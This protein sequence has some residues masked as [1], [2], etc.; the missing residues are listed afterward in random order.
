MKTGAGSR[1][2]SDGRITLAVPSTESTIRSLSLSESRKPYTSMDKG[3]PIQT[4]AED[5]T[6]GAELARPTVFKARSSSG[7][8]VP[9]INVFF[10][11]KR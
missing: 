10:M 5:S 2:S 11:G 1:S 9:S 4:I 7:R 8:I 6:N 3:M